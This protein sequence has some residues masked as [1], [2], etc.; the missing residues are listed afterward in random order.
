MWVNGRKIIV[1]LVPQEG[2]PRACDFCSEILVDEDARLLCDCYLTDYG[3]MCKR[4]LGDIKPIKT[5]HQ[6]ESVLN[7]T[8]Y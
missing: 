2:T 7:E 4:C 1:R 8:W 3:L 5:Y 6:G